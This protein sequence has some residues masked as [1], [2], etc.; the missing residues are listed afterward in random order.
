MELEE[1]RRVESTARSFREEF[2]IVDGISLPRSITFL[3]QELEK[4]TD[5]KSRAQLYHLIYVECM[6]ANLPDLEIRY[7]HRE[8]LENPDDPVPLI[9]LA[10]R[11]A[12]RPQGATEA[13]TTIERAVAIASKV[14]RFIRYALLT[15][16]RI[17]ADQRDAVLLA[18]SLTRLI[19]DSSNR[20]DE[21]IPRMEVDFLNG[22]PEGFVDPSLV[23]DYLEVAR[24]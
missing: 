10:G 7:W 9:G 5:P 13:L 16:A 1:F 12:I 24:Q 19:S 14:N 17:A 23:S 11:L 15:R 2:D 20:R 18:D 22:L 21:D 3:D 4:C 8:V 6:K